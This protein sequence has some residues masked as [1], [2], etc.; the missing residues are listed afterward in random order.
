MRR[1]EMAV[2]LL[3]AALSPAT[4]AAQPQATDQL[5]K[6]FQP[7]V[8]RDPDDVFSYNKLGAVYVQ[9]ARESGDLTYYALAE[10]AARRSTQLVPQGPSAAAATTLL[11][12][13]HHA[14]HEFREALGQAQQALQLGGADVSPHAI[15]GDALV[16]LGDYDGAIR[17]YSRLLGLTGPRHP[18]GR[19][20]YLRVLQGDAEAAL[21]GMRRAVEAA[22]GASPSREPPA[23]AP[24]RAGARAV[25]ARRQ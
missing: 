24:A 22:R 20:A 1:R 21:A 18:H 5:L 7:R 9:K 8:A 25:P 23:G 4:L 16:E 10:K 3:L 13:V 15:A 17:A 2:A 19:L 6:F 14:R 11:A 12:L